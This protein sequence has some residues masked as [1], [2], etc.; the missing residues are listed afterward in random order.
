MS[1]LLGDPVQGTDFIALSS[2]FNQNPLNSKC[3][4]IVWKSE[5]FLAKKV[6]FLFFFKAHLNYTVP[7][8]LAEHPG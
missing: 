5:R 7:P 2:F 1:R 4:G 6:H 3:N 8:V